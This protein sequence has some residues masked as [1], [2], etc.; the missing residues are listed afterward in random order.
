MYYHYIITLVQT[1]YIFI[2]NI[3]SFQTCSMMSIYFSWLYL[4]IYNSYILFLLIILCSTRHTDCLRR[5]V[6]V[7]LTRCHGDEGTS[8]VSCV[9]TFTSSKFPPCSFVS[10]SIT[11]WCNTHL[12]LLSVSGESQV[13]LRWVPCLRTVPVSLSLW[14]WGLFP[15]LWVNLWSSV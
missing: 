4:H 14:S 7:L 5:S 3:F 8:C 1:Q 6:D 9:F 13:N 12:L 10:W 2:I 15:C 11:V